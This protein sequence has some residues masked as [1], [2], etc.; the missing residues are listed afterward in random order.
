[1][2]HSQNPF[3]V[4]RIRYY[5]MDVCKVSKE[6]CSVGRKPIELCR[7]P[8]AG[9]ESARAGRRLQEGVVAVVV[10]ASTLMA[11]VCL[12]LSVLTFIGRLV[13]HAGAFL[14]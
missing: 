8:V 6:I 13:R 10:S 14:W 2:V 5:E 11:G 7:A 1:M 4:A 12:C 3:R 9:G